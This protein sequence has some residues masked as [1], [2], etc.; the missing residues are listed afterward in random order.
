[1]DSDLDLRLGQ[2]QYWAE[3][4]Q[5]KDTHPLL[6]LASSYPLP[7]PLQSHAHLLTSRGMMMG[8]P[9]KGHSLR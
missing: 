4:R 8:T 7:P 6:P 1:M 5:P 9:V 3:R 2:L